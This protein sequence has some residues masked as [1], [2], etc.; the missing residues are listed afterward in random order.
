MGNAV[1][2]ATSTAFVLMEGGYVEKPDSTVY[3]FPLA[4]IDLATGRDQ[5]DPPGRALQ[6][7]VSRAVEELFQ[8]PGR[9][10][11]VGTLSAG[12]H[13]GQR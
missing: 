8:D 12:S 7:K 9:H 1:A 3:R 13:S 10:P 11:D 2:F 4:V 5:G 6:G